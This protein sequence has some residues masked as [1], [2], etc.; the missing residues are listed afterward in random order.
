[1]SILINVDFTISKSSISKYFIP[2]HIYRLTSK[3]YLS[4]INAKLGGRD[5]TDFIVHPD[6]HYTKA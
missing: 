3:N 1:M 5:N 4:I 6:D 2:P